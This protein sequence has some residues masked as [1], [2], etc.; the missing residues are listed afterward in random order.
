MTDGD[1]R[2]REY[3]QAYLNL[4]GC[5]WTDVAS[6]PLGDLETLAAT[7]A[8]RPAARELKSRDEQDANYVAS[9]LGQPR[10]YI[11]PRRDL[12]PDDGWRER[13][14]LTFPGRPDVDR[15]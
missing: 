13:I 9:I 14:V 1:G 3:L 5:A 7:V 4:H 6:R 10:V 15:T 8:Q 12:M 2:R 11:G